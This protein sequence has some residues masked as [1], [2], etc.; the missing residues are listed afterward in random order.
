MERFDPDV[1]NVLSHVLLLGQAV[2]CGPVPQA[3]L[4]C[5]LHQGQTRIF[6]LHL[7]SRYTG[8]LDGEATPWDGCSFAFLGEITQGF[9]STVTLPDNAFCMI[10]NVRAQT[11]DYMAIHLDELTGIGFPPVGQADPEANAV[12][13]P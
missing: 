3:Y 11:S 10:F 2:G 7:P 13:T 9:V 6:C 8:S 5:A 12:S 4:C 1:N